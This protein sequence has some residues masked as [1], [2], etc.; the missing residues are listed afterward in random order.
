MSW[1]PDIDPTNRTI[2]PVGLPLAVISTSCVFL[3]LGL[4][5]TGIRLYIRIIDRVFG[6]DDWF[7]AFGCVSMIGIV[8]DSRPFA[9]VPGIVKMTDCN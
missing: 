6:L 4:V 3:V 8:M 7:M 1:N 5:L 9:V 2:A